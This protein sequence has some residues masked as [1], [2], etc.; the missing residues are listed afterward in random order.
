M[1]FR[2]R[3]WRPLP[4]LGVGLGRRGG[5]RQPPPHPPHRHAYPLHLCPLLRC[6]RHLVSRENGSPTSPLLTFIAGARR[7]RRPAPRAR[8]GAGAGG[9]RDSSH[10]LGPSRYISVNLGGKRD[11]S[12]LPAALCRCRHT[13]RTLPQTSTANSS[14]LGARGRR[15]RGGGEGGELLPGRARRVRRRLAQH[16]RR[17]LPDEERPACARVHRALAAAQRR[18]HG[19]LAWRAAQPA[20]V[21]EPAR[22]RRQGLEGRVA[23]GEE[24][25]AGGEEAHVSR[26]AIKQ[27]REN[28]RTDEPNTA[29]PQWRWGTQETQ[30]RLY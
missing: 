27:P 9:K 20:R 28:A 2:R 19:S 7:V 17:K 15:Q 24:E 22:G 8:Q 4:L 1:R 18:R 26:F 11:S 12:P 6:R 10:N 14:Q 3:R 13:T 16:L 30:V 5:A 29:T 23:G 21:R 25:G